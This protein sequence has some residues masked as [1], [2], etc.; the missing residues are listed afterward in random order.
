MMGESTFTLSNE[1]LA[2]DI[3]VARDSLLV[4]FDVDL[5]TAAGSFPPDVSSWLVRPALVSLRVEPGPATAAFVAGPPSIASGAPASLSV[6]VTDDN[7][8]LVKRPYNVRF[9]DS[10]GHD[11]GSS[12]SEAGTAL[13]QFVPEASVPRRVRRADVH[14]RPGEHVSGAGHHRRVLQRGSGGF[15]RWR[16]AEGRHGLPGAEPG[17]GAADLAGRCGQRQPFGRGCAIRRVSPRVR[18]ASTSPVSEVEASARCEL[19]SLRGCRSVTLQSTFKATHAP[20]NELGFGRH[21]AAGH[22][23][24]R[25][26]GSR[27]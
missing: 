1:G 4:R 15:D 20:P 5:S 10:E 6:E 11:L 12:D 8:R 19:R 22:S 7:G 13:M 14:Q 26:N 17:R 2:V 24:R 18:P 16:A 23:P 3:N 27:R 25:F 21:V 9:V